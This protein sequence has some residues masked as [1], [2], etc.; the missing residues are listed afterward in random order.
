MI[1]RCTTG[2]V[3]HH[4]EHFRAS[5]PESGHPRGRRPDR[6]AVTGT[7]D[8]PL[9]ALADHRRGR[10]EASAGDVEVDAV[11]SHPGQGLALG[12]IPS[13]GTVQ[14]SVCRSL[15]TISVVRGGGG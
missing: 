9:R 7:L 14:K 4:G 2:L 10:A 15:T 6:V 13:A 12:Q 1:A 3:Y 11:A 5:L 8:P